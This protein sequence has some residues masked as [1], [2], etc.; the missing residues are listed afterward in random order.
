[1]LAFYVTHCIITACFY[2]S[3]MGDL[4]LL[5]RPAYYPAPDLTS[6]AI[7]PE[8]EEF[9]KHG[10]HF[11]IMKLLTWFFLKIKTNT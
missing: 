10:R 3:T 2:A 5:F 8:M 4:A 7:A 6:S 9:T 11:L 1:M